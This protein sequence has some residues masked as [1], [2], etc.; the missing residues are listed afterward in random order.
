MVRLI[1]EINPGGSSLPS[2]FTALGP[3]LYFAADDGAGAGWGNHELW[4]SDGTEAGTALVREIAPPPARASNPGQQTHAAFQG[5]VYFSASNGFSEPL[6]RSDGTASGTFIVNI[7]FPSVVPNSLTEAGGRLYIS[8]GGGAPD[9]YLYRYDGIDLVPI[10]RSTNP[11][12]WGFNPFEPTAL[13]R[14]LV[15]TENSG[16]ELWRTDGNSSIAVAVPDPALPPAELPRSKR[17]LTAVGDTL[18]FAAAAGSASGKELWTYRA[19]EPTTAKVAFIGTGYDPAEL[20]AVGNRLFFVGD[21]SRGAELWISDGTAAGTTLVRDINPTAGAGAPGPRRGPSQLTAVSDRAVF[22]AANDGSSGYELWRSDGTADGTQRLLDI[23]PG[24]ASSHPRDLIVRGNLLYFTAGDDTNGRQLW[25]TDTLT[26]TTSRLTSRSMLG[27]SSQFFV[28]NRGNDRNLAIAGDTLFLSAYSSDG[29][30]VSGYELWGL[31]LPSLVS[32]SLPSDAVPRQLSEDGPR[33]LPIVFRRSGDTSSPLTV[34]FRVGGKAR[35]GID[36]TLREAASL[37]P[38]GGSI[39]FAAG[40]S[41]AT[42]LLDPSSDTLTE[43]NETEV[44]ALLSAAD[45]VVDGTS[46]DLVITLIDNDVPAGQVAGAPIPSVLASSSVFETRNAF[47]FAALKAGG[48]VV[49]WGDANSGGD[50]SAVATQL[51]SDVTRIASTSSAFAALK[52]DGSVVPWGNALFGGDAGAVASQL[53]GDVLQIVATGF[54]FAALKRDGSVITWG[55]SRFGNLGGDSS[56]VRSRL[57]ADVQQ[58]FAGPRAFAALK[59]DG[60]VVA[61]GDA[62]SGG[63]TAGVGSAL[64]AGVV[65]ITAGG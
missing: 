39:T 43:D 54:A 65:A 64:N 48:S 31:D 37:S 61:W 53:T 45:Y 9:S 35:L 24:A 13:G 58:V 30:A 5:N 16:N 33:V 18:F 7:A 50:I 52:A 4:R 40:A 57:A 19:G 27:P 42:L 22:F 56:A 55:D 17:H 51:A 49:A 38:T 62:N 10:R 63:S 8:F 23:N 11:W 32:L 28:Q 41:T 36:Y 1:K 15:F 47:A 3:W 34:N 59:N 29:A 21:D 2:R 6:W 46:S 60:S 20:T 44:V 26:N 14:N 12:E 25:A